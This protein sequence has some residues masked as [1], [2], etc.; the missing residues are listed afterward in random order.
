DGIK[1]LLAGVPDIRIIGEANSGEELL[2]TI[3]IKQPDI[4]LMDISLPDISGID[5]TRMLSQSHPEIRVLI[6]SMYTNEDFVF[7]AMK[8]GASGYL[9][10]NTSRQ[11]LLDA[12][13]AIRG[14]LEFFSDS[15]SKVI[16]KSF[17]RQATQSEGENGDSP[18]SLTTREQEILKLFAEGYNNKEISTRLSISIRTVESH[19]NHIVKKLGLKST[20]EMVKF[21]IK[22]KIVE[23]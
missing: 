15:I 8:A 14:G 19:K 18:Q 21:A 11:E 16:L 7:N 5:L 9:P 13:Y 1:A 20:V 23:L 6:L 10:K 12:I 4:I 2:E 3:K 22:N 17:L